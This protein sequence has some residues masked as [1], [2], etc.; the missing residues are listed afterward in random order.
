MVA[1]G[2]TGHSTPPS[3]PSPAASLEEDFATELGLV[4]EIGITPLLSTFAKPDLHFHNNR[5]STGSGRYPRRT[6]PVPEV[7]TIQSLPL[8]CVTELALHE[9]AVTARLTLFRIPHTPGLPLA[10]G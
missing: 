6:L 2:R 9:A 1:D 7:L 5:A 3:C 4:H 10:H 8:R